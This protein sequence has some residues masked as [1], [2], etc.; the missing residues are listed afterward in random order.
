MNVEHSLLILSKSLFSIQSQKTTAPALPSCPLPWPLPPGP[1]PPSDPKRRFPTH[2]HCRCCR[3]CGEDDCCGSYHRSLADC[4]GSCRGCGISQSK[5]VPWRDA[6]AAVSGGG[7]PS[8][9]RPPVGSGRTIVRPLPKSLRCCV[10]V[11]EN[12]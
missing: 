7:V 5:A 8:P 2:L 1:S 6:A 12:N 11:D 10:K 4:G 9:L 3:C